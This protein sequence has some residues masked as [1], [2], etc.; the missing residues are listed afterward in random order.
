MYGNF[1]AKYLPKTWQILCEHEAQLHPNCKH[2][3]NCECTWLP[4]QNANGFSEIEVL[5]NGLW[6]PITNVK[7]HKKKF[8]R[9]LTGIIPFNGYSGDKHSKE[10]LE[11]LAV[12]Q[13]QWPVEGKQIYNMLD[14][15]KV[16]KS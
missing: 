12:I 14:V 3:W 5:V 7:V 1:R 16:K 11:L 13:K 8:I 4:G 9:S 2:E 15:L 6:V 10:S